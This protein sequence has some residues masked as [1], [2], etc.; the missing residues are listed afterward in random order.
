MEC[1]EL[2]SDKGKTVLVSG[3]AVLVGD[4]PLTHAAT[5]RSAVWERLVLANPLEGLKPDGQALATLAN[6][7][8]SDASIM[9]L[10]QLM[11]LFVAE[12]AM[13]EAGLVSRR[14]RIRGATHP[15]RYRDIGC[16]SGSSLSGMPEFEMDIVHGK[17]LS[18]YAM[19]RWRGNSV[20]AAVTTRFGLGGGD[21]SLNA[22]SATGAQCLYLAGTLIQAGV[23][24]AMVVVAA[25]AP[26][27][28]KLSE[29][30]QRNGSV[31]KDPAH[32]PLSASRSGMNPV[33]GAACLIL[34]SAERLRARGGRALAA[35]TGGA[36]ANEAFHMLAPEPTG[37]VLRELLGCISVP[38]DWVSLHA[39]GTP[40]FD[41]IEIAV[42]NAMQGP[43]GQWQPW[44]TAIKSVTGHALGASGLIEA[45]LVIEGLG[46]G[47]VPPW[48][49]HTDPTLQLDRL[50]P[51]SAPRPKSAL[52]IGQGMGGNVVVN[53]L[54]A[55]TS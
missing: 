51:Q 20:G 53:G 55:V 45:A 52:L 18:P 7:E 47:E 48:P 14:Q 23:C 40:S 49:L 37:S 17:K 31:T 54:S 42:I 25:D 11:A 10:H 13:Q 29:A 1:D 28:P 41:A 5:M 3:A 15:H 21:Y 19:S 24:E 43:Y 22:A 50:R 12:M 35:W 38:P 33:P 30:M 4:L 9:G 26:A 34:E 36:C 32:G 2:L 6:L 16:V 27:T 44:L 8:P 46:R 39:T